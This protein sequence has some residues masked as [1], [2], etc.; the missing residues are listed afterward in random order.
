M[1]RLVHEISDAHDEE[2]VWG[3][4]W[5][6]D[7]LHLAS[8]GQD[9]CIRVFSIQGGD[10]A[11]GPGSKPYPSDLTAGEDKSSPA[12]MTPRLVATMEEGQSRTIR[13]V[14]W[15]PCGRSIAAA[16]FDGRL[17]QRSEAI[18]IKSC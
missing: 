4:A 3:I 6:P 8:C 10:W 5:S 13:S 15:S 12:S 11:E 9:K 17:C 14:H 16:S 7:G 18:N 2:G 1:L